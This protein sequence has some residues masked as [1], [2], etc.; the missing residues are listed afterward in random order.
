MNKDHVAMTQA[1][2]LAREALDAGE[3]PVG[4]VITLDADILAASRRETSIGTLPS[5]ITH[6]EILALRQLEQI[7]PMNERK[8]ATLY[9]TLEP[10]L[11]CYAAILLSG[12]GRIVWAY[13]DAMGGGTNC[14]LHED[15]PPFYAS[16]QPEIRSHF[17]RE[18]SLSLFK[19][20]F[21][22][23]KNSYWKD[24][25]LARYTLAAP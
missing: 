22:N 21:S 16:R 5:E 10:C 3:F 2:K 24:S 8:N 25:P 19:L 12:L 23:P 1:L 11:M 17:L 9:T 13:E 20:F 15:L 14:N 18:A 4:C 7:L 6:A